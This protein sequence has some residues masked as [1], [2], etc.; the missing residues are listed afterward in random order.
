[1]E[2]ALDMEYNTSRPKLQIPEYGRNVQKMVDFA[3]TLED[4]DERNKVANAIIN[5][6]G[7]LNKHLRDE[8]DYKHKLWTHLFII[9]DFKLD[10]DSPYPIPNREML[11]EKPN[12]VNYPQTKIQFGHYGKTIEGMIAI[13][14][15]MPE[16]EEREAL[17]K[18]I[19][20]LMK[21]FHLMYN[22][23][24]I[25]DEIISQHLKRM[26]KGKII[27]KD[28]SFLTATKDILKDY[29]INKKPVQS[30]KNR[31]NNKNRNNRNRKRY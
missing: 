6:M 18:V 30:N 27:L 7:E 3:I 29:E 2:T 24:S 22:T 5:V 14:S 8:E 11:A 19:A 26:S 28:L 15:E 4:R 13:A 23:N 16:N 1:M 20:D 12:K 21:R 31:K 25:D 10:V 9:S 17:V